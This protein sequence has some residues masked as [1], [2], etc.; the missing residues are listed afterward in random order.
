[1]SANIAIDKLKFTVFG[2]GYDDE[3]GNSGEGSSTWVKEIYAIS[4]FACIDSTENYVWLCI[5]NQVNPRLRKYNID[6]WEMEQP[7]TIPTNLAT[8]MYHPSNVS[9]NIGIAF[10]NWGSNADVYVIDLT[11]DEIYQH[12][13]VDTSSTYINY[14]ADCI[15]VD[16]VIYFSNTGQSNNNIIKLD[17][18][19]ETI[20]L[21]SNVNY[22]NGGS[23]GF[24][25]ESTV[26][27][28]TDPLWFSNYAYRYGY[29]IDGTNLWTL[30][31]RESGSGGFP[32]CY[33]KGFCGNGY[34]WLPVEINDRW[35]WGK[36]NGH[37]GGD[38]YTPSPLDIVGDFENVP[39]P[40]DFHVYYADGRN[41][42]ATVGSNYGLIVTDLEEHEV[43]F[44]EESYAP[45]AVSDEY[46]IDTSASYVVT[47]LI[48]YR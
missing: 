1:M 13:N 42:V 32:H 23:C 37:T 3:R 33:S 25:D 15:M 6:T 46:V 43:Y 20:S 24:V 44:T 38:L 26:Y 31:G 5:A 48:K 7:I 22:G 41:I 35:H 10:Q 28:Y 27:G 39:E 34:M 11:T 36:F 2:H 12:F 29:S 40:N 47:K 14:S 21:Y 18:T 8:R 30:Q 9:N 45:L 4:D 19:N 16:D 17:L